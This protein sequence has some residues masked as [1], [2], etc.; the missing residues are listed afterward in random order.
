MSHGTPGYQDKRVDMQVTEQDLRERYA[1]AETEQLL[2][3]QAQGTL[4]ETATRVLEQELAERS[5]ATEDRAAFA[6]EFKKQAAAQDEA[7][8]SLASRE[9]RLGAQLIDAVVTLLILFLAALFSLAARPF[10]FLGIIVALAYLLLADGFPRGQSLGKRVVNIAV[11]DRRTHQPCTYGQSFLRNFLL[12]LL[13]IID[14]IFIFGR[15]RQRLGDLAANTIVV[16]LKG[17]EGAHAGG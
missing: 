6:S 2:E 5:I 12:A 11:I 14:W 13:G 17:S 8:A 9:A 1:A 15:T 7:M 16:R 10:G 3:L 4:T